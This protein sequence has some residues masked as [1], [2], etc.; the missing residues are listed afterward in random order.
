MNHRKTRN[1][2]YSI[3]RGH[4]LS[5]QNQSP[6][7]GQ[8]HRKPA[9]ANQHHGHLAILALTLALGFGLFAGA[10]NSQAAAF[11]WTNTT[12]SAFNDTNAWVSPSG[13]LPGPSD[14]ASI[15]LNGTLDIPLTN[16]FISN[17]GTLLF[18]A[19]SSSGSAN[20]T[21][22]FGTN[23]FTGVSGNGNNVSGFVFGQT[24]TTTVYIACGAILCTNSTGNARMIVG[25]QNGP[26]AVFLTNGFIAAG[27]LIIANNASTANGSKVVISG[28]NSS[29]S[30]SFG[31]LIGNTAGS[32]SNSLVISNSGSMVSAGSLQ[33][34]NAGFFNSL[35]LDTSGRLFTGNTGSLGASAASSNNTATVQGGA[36]WDCGAQRLFVGNASGQNNA[37]I[38][39]DH[40]TVSNITFLTITTGGN[41]LVISG[42]VLS[43][44]G[45]IT[46][47]S[48]KISG[49]GTIAG[50]VVF[51][52][53]GTLTPGFG[54]TPGTLLL[55]NNL[56]L[57]PGSTTTMKLDRGQPGSNDVINV[58]SNLTQAGTLTINNVG[59]VPV[60]GDTFKLFVFGSASGNF[61]VTNLPALSGSLVWDTTKLGS[62]GIISVDLS[63]S[64]TGPGDQAAVTNNDV[65][66]SATVTGVP[67]PTLQWQ[68]G[69]VNVSDGATTN[70]GS[71]ISGSTSHTLT[72]LNAQLGDSGQY[73]LIASNFAGSVTNC[74][75]LTVT[76]N[77]AAPTIT[78]PTDQ[79]TILHSNATFSASVAGIP[80][81]TQKW[82]E[83]GIDIPGAAGLSI[84]ITNVSSAQD[85]NVYR[86]IAS[87]SEGAAT[88]NATLHVV[89][90]P[91]IAIQPQSLTV[92]NTQSASFS[93]TY[94]NAVPAPTY[95]WKKNNV[96]IGNA[97]NAIYTI[98][99]ASPSDMAAYSVVLA[100]AA[101][102]ITSS[103][104]TLTVNSTMTASLAPSNSATTVCYDTPLYMAFDRTP[105]ASGTGQ[106]RIFN[107][108]NSVT[109]VDTIDT[110]LG[111]L[112][113]R[114]IG[115]ET[116]NTFP[117]IITSNTVAIY[118]HLGVLTS[119]QTYYVTVDA[120]TFS[121]TNGAL[122][123]GITDTN[124]WRFTTKPTGPTDPNNLWVT[125]DGSG[126]FCTVQGAVDS[127]PINNG[128]LR[129]IN[130][131]NG[132]YT[133][134]VD[135]RSKSNI[136]FRGQSR[137]G[138]VV[139]YTNNNNQNGS[140]HSRMTFKVF[141]NDISIE[142][143]TIINTT[144]QGGSQAEALMIDTGA[145]RFILNNAEVDS[146]QD[147][148]LA[149]VNSSQGY[150][151]N[152]LIRGNFDYVWGGGNCFFTNCEMRTIPT[153]S[154]YNLTA[155]RTDN[156]T[157]PGGWLG[158]DGK[159]ASNGFSIVD[160][161]LTRSDN[162][163]T[164]MTPV[165]SNGAADGNAA[166]IN[167]RIDTSLYV[168][169]SA[170]V[171]NSYILWEYNNSNLDNTASASLGLS[172][173][174]N[175][176]ARLV[177]AQNA[178]T[179]LYG[180]SPQL[181][182]NIL[183]NPVSLTVTAGVT[184]TFTVTATGISGSI[185]PVAQ[186]RHQSGRRH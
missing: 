21:L 66:I 101:G 90:P 184:A 123:A 167:C 40:G 129:L 169:P 143:L 117:I 37:L 113:S 176:D 29:W 120:A 75:T 175:G 179:W 125:A 5:A 110:S 98:A 118:P 160:C 48:A 171:T 158:P 124:A 122:F 116:F 67:V 34:G 145:A 46:N 153:A 92:T 2:A 65:T 54:T 20:I 126:D 33:V 36:V 39:G 58:V 138:T 159:Y 68:L 57:V 30:N 55:S 97:T 172:V 59:A 31:C 41:S 165:G 80:A 28:P 180:W 78:G 146:R 131:R 43:A 134:I 181:A 156:G 49:F 82:Q 6:A 161:Q 70:G 47:G 74:M 157:T 12:G 61:A 170:S 51:T 17:V 102:S 71:T 100:N 128:T 76:T 107:A 115:T 69:G 24:G 35:V 4:S 105:V 83:N 96:A 60:G 141:S 77:G 127:V 3:V 26:T 137:A 111:N 14:T 50:D 52:G 99:S 149:N 177:A 27:N 183:T 79:S 139:Q 178:G 18:G 63:P 9:A 11:V 173:L 86:I 140:T 89:I 81:P 185:I 88:N 95:Q 130:I 114:T 135:T 148:I 154:T 32:A 186:G 13:G 72:I 64:I 152:S 22:D 7:P 119:N 91:D 19:A 73:C 174:T 142:N 133:E 94:T 45:A 93:V 155:P 151:C 44:S 132:T 168:P 136:T 15:T 16:N 85:G 166:F 56:T 182:P 112:Q 104:A 121:D 23:V 150:F 164:N 147:T 38:V 144:P 103:N 87:N 109:P 53:T 10:D 162:N 25:R 42:G 106:I 1:R 8:T 108:T 62:Q 84:T 163:V